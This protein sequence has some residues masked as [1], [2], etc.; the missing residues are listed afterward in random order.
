MLGNLPDMHKSR[1]GDELTAEKMKKCVW[2]RPE[3]AAQVEFLEWTDADRL[4]HSKFVG[5][6]DDKIPRTVI[7]ETEARDAFVAADGC[8]IRIGIRIPN[9]NL[10]SL[11][12]RQE[13]RGGNIADLTYGGTLRLQFFSS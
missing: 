3:V 9:S 4:R 7:K 6:R 12:M 13:H 8:R 1:W 10:R 11:T 2:L 5:L